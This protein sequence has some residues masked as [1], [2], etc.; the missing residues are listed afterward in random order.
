MPV[1]HRRSRTFAGDVASRASHWPVNLTITFRRSHYLGVTVHEPSDDECMARQIDGSR[2][3]LMAL[4]AKATITKT[5]TLVHTRGL[6]RGSRYGES[7]CRG[8]PRLNKDSWLTMADSMWERGVRQHYGRAP[9]C[10]DMARS[11]SMVTGSHRDILKIPQRFTQRR[12]ERKSDLGS[13][14]PSAGATPVRRA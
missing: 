6:F 5:R 8:T 7:L 14:F 12:R 1:K 9:Y 3:A 4:S 2:E 11:D 10:E 13:G